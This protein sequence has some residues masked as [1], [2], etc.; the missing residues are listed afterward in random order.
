[1]RVSARIRSLLSPDLQFLDDADLLQ[2]YAYPPDLTA[3]WVRANMVSSIDG[4][5]AF[6]GASRGLT[7][8]PDRRL[9]HLMRAMADV[10]LIGAGTA[11]S[12]PYQDHTKQVVV[13]TRSGDLPAHFFTGKRP[14]VITSAAIDDGRR[15]ALAETAQV[16][17]RGRHEVDLDLVRRFF[18]ERGWLKVLCE[19]GP[20]LL[21]SLNAS[22]LIDE[23]ALTIAPLLVGNGSSLFQEG[24]ETKRSFVLAS[25]LEAEGNLFA[26]YVAH[27]VPEGEQRPRPG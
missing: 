5:A 19:G 20:A 11:R 10:I 9:F 26:R 6:E 16:I 8:T 3:P 17:V 7:S 18:I 13:V 23:V 22:A 21:G 27:Q 14:V 12:E 4:S 15:H 1:M 2:M 25:L 24:P